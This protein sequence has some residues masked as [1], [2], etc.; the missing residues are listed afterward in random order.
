M[1][2]AEISKMPRELWSERRV[3]VGLDFLD[4]EGKMLTN[5]AEEVDGRLGVVVVV[6]AQ[7]AKT[8]SFI[9]RR[10]LI[11]ALTSS[12]H[13]RNE[14]N[15]ELNRAAGNLQ[16]SVRWFR[17][18]SILFE[19]DAADT[20]AMEYFQ[21]GCGRDVRVVVALKVQAGSDGTIAAL[22]SD[23]EDQRDNLGWNAKADVVWSPRLIPKT[24]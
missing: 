18:G 9:N 11:K 23:A 8:R 2:D 5:F 22:F 14:L 20:V 19:G 15:I 1:R 4:G 21:N 6:D 10:E 12:P 3:V 7:N 17:A 24:S 13:T 16:G